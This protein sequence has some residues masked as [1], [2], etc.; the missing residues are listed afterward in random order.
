MRTV[1]AF[2]TATDV[3]VAALGRCPEEHEDAPRE[4]L[5]ELELTA[6]RAANTR[7]LP[8][9]VALL[10]EASL[11]AGDLD[12]VVVGRGPGSFTGVRIGVATA[13]GLAQGL[14]VP[15]YGAS[16]LDAVAWRFAYHDGLV[17]VVGDAMRQEVYPALF[18][19]G[20]GRV[21]RVSRDVVEK[22]AETAARW[23]AET[24]E[25]LLLAG[26]ALAKHADALREGLGERATIAPPETWPPSGGGLLAAALEAL[27]EAGRG[28]PGALLPVYTR[29][30][31]AEEAE[32]RRLGRK[33]ERNGTGVAGPAEGER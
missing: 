13:K 10:C 29:L 33:A 7:L 1:L 26:N 20:D 12:A 15:L 30:A 32:A 3:I 24:D 8:S 18:R 31:D 21:E 6:V 5:A 22:P 23:A 4:V 9:V 28:D 16:T 11:R 25:P 2:D 27:P 17:G 14:G 19:C